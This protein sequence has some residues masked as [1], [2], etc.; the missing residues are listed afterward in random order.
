MNEYVTILIYTLWI[1]IFY[2]FPENKMFSSS[3]SFL[4]IDKLKVNV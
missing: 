3:L 2:S 4:I 1:Y